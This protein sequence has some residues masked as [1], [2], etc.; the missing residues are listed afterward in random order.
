[1]PRR[2]INGRVRAYKSK[3]DRILAENIQR[4]IDESTFDS[5]AGWA[6]DKG[7]NPRNIQRILAGEQSPGVVLLDEIACKT[8]VGGAWRLLVPNLDMANLP[9]ALSDMEKKMYADLQEKAKALVAN[10]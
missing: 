2:N 1:M 8:K 10:R 3:T 7:L 4:M 5:V 9:V 6:S